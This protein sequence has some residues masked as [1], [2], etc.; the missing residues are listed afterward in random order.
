V[1]AVKAETGGVGAEAANGLERRVQANLH[2]LRK[3]RGWSSSKLIE[4]RRCGDLLAK[5]SN[6]PKSTL[7]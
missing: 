7:L 4:I 1:D 5:A 6:P 3:V 2:Y